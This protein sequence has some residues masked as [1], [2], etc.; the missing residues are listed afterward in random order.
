MAKLIYDGSEAFSNKV[1]DFNSK[2]IPL[3][4]A[5]AVGCMIDIDVAV[6]SAVVCAS[7]T[8][9]THGS[10]LFT[11]AHDF[12]TGLKVQVTT[13]SALPTGLSLATDYFV[14]VVDAGVS[15]KVASSYANAIA[16][17]PVDITNN[18]T[19]NQTF[20]P[21][22]ISATYAV[23]VSPTDASLA[24]GKWAN[25]A[26]PTAITADTT[27]MPVTA[28]NQLGVLGF[29]YMRYAFT[30]TAGRINATVYTHA[31]SDAE[32]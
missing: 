24:A 16:G 28:A 8:D 7:A 20:T 31:H 5:S 25:V 11:K 32:S 21:V 2:F 4:G 29:K 17:T 12:T 1:T 15:F 3:D 13:S 18:G 9:I 27:V 6:P 10:D 26:S 14:I 19:G 23:Q 30:I 22:A